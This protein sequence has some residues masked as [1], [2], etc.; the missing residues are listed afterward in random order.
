[1]P[2]RPIAVLFDLDGTLVDT[3]GFILASVRHTFE[4]Y[5]GRAPTDAEWIA[6]IGTPLRAQLASFAERPDHVEPLLERY[7]AHQRLHF[8]RMTRPFEG[9]V[10]VVRELAARGHPVGVV[11]AKLHEPAERA[12]RLI[13]LEGCVEVIVSADSCPRC[14]P[15]PDPVLLALRQVGREPAEALFV[16]DSPHDIA[17]GNAAGAVSAAALWGAC[18]REV[19]EAAGPGHLLADV[20]EVPALVERLG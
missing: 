5:G 12:V 4:G 3:I 9:A 10:E 19:L 13:G 15:H 17:A 20:R 1:M 8:E 18:T 6:G 14:K 7:R 16:G 2:A 11:T